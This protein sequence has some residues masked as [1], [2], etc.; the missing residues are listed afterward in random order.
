M[1]ETLTRTEA[2]GKLVTLAKEME[3]TNADFIPLEVD[4]DQTYEMCANNVL[5]QMYSVPDDHRETVMLATLTKLLTENLLLH[6]K[7]KE[8]VKNESN[9][10]S[11]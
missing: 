2:V 10:N 7:I 6:I 8:K 4:I 3:V 9:S 5:T 1:T 11:N